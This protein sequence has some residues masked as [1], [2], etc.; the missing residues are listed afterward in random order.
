[1]N[2]SELTV[3]IGRGLYEPSLTRF[4]DRYYLTLRNDDAGD[5]AVSPDGVRFDTPR[6]WWAASWGTTTR[7]ST[8]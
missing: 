1:M 8:G 3:D 6:M 5:V 7:S 2:S 4:R